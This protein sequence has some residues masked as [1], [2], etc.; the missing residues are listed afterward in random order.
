VD[1]LIPD[2]NFY[3]DFAR[4]CSA[5]QISVD[6]FLFSPHYTDVATIATLARVTGGQTY[7]YPSFSAQR[8]GD[9]FAADLRHNLTRETAWEAV[10]RVRTTKGVKVA[11]HYGNFSIRSTDLMAL[12]A[13][14]SDKGFGVQM[15][16]SETLT[17]SRYVSVQNALLY[18]TSSGERRIRVAT[19]CLPVTATLADLFRFADLSA[20][21]G[22][23]A[24]MAVEKALKF[25]LSDARQALMNKCVDILAAYRTSFSSASTTTTQLVLPETLK[26]LPVYTLALMKHIAFRSG[27][28]IR[29]D[30]RSW[31]LALMR[32]QPLP[33]TISLLYPCLYALHA[34]PHE[35]SSQCPGEFTPLSNL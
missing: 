13:V 2:K 29:P 5:Q 26:N 35:V 1:L 10:M 11:V 16:I 3:E 8:D 28:D 4:D 6:P 14:D 19:V 30:E 23:T 15:Q 33:A 32:A 25:K 27:S 31:Y 12:P 22:L 21:V 34:L 20:V 9:K 17:A 18:T 7:Y 24:K